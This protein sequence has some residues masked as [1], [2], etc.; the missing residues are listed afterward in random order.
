[1]TAIVA[2]EPSPAMT[3]LKRARKGRRIL[4]SPRTPY[5]PANA[6][7]QSGVSLLQVLVEALTL[8]QTLVVQT[9][10]LVNFNLLRRTVSL[11][12]SSLHA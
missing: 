1:M 11:A 10:Q 6:C 4:F 2:S 9:P 3:A 12:Q 5:A 7:W 8:N